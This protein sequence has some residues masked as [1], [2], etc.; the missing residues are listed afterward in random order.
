M[1]ESPPLDVQ[2]LAGGHVGPGIDVGLMIEFG[3]DYLGARWE[4][5]GK[6]EVTKELGGGGADDWNLSVL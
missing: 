2:V 6:G 3:E 4:C 5:Q 1:R